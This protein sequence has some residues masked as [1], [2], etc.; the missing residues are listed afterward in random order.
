[1]SWRPSLLAVALL[2]GL[3]ALLLNAPELA[4]PADGWSG[5]S[6][7]LVA[8]WLVTAVLLVWLMGS[9]LALVIASAWPR[10][11]WTETVAARSPAWLRRLAGVAVAASSLVAT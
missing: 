6:L 5:E 1:M 2:G 4:V 10:Q 7:T 9:C 11:R 3:G 8:T